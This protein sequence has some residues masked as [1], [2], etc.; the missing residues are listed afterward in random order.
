MACLST[1]GDVVESEDRE[2]LSGVGG[3]DEAAFWKT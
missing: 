2:A 1:E 3:G